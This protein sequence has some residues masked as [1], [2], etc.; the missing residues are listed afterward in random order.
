MSFLIDFT[1]LDAIGSNS[2][3]LKIKYKL[4]EKQAQEIISISSYDPQQSAS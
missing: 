2:I 3:N 1:F 4:I